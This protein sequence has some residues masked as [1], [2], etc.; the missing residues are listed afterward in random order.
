[1]SCAARNVAVGRRRA[2]MCACA[3]ALAS[4]LMGAF[5]ATGA[6]AATSQFEALAES[7]VPLTSVAVNPATNTIYA[8]QY[9]G[10]KFY[11]YS[12]ST[13]AWTELAAAPLN[14]G[15]N[16]GAAYLNGRIYTSYTENGTELGVYDIAEGKW[17][18]IANPLEG[19]TADI[20]AYGED[21]YLV[22]GT[23]FVSYDPET[24]VTTELAAPPSFAALKECES[25]FEKWGA[26][27]PYEGKIYGD[28]GNGCRGFA[29]YDVA[30]NSWSE[31]PEL[32]NGAVAGGTIDPV[33]ASYFAYGNYG[34]DSLYRY[35]I[36]GGSWHTIELPFKEV[37]DGGMAYVSLAGHSGVYIIQGQEADAFTRFGGLSES[38]LIT[39]LSATLTPTLGGGEVTYTAKVENLG[40]EG[41][42]G[43]TLK[44]TLPAGMTLLSAS[45]TPGSCTGTTTV[46]CSLGTLNVKASATVT[47]KVSAK[48]GTYA[49]SVAVSSEGFEAS[50][51]FKS[52]SAS[53][54]IASALT[55]PPVVVPAPAVK[56]CVV[57]RLRG[58]PL[59]KVKRELKAGG[60]RVGRVVR[61]YNRK[62]RKGSIIYGNPHAHSTLPAGTRVNLWV[63]L[64]KVPKKG[65]RTTKGVHPK[66]AA[67]TPKTAKK[68]G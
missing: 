58:V 12:P 64:G 11:S 4:A 38:D 3:A 47:I 60:C 37:N 22:V 35:S 52:A 66:H 5:A 40:P 59:A 24:K 25:G 23:K 62:I 36:V 43:A 33:S 49:N 30:T 34:G 8:Q 9:E 7:P 54:A 39:S 44:D 26:L 21:L 45:S 18:T 19:G 20:T 51:L 65:A 53:T 2:V 15:N 6:R 32:P 28:Q 63:S 41:A 55:P 56:H 61:H 46:T 42:P 48:P 10:T 50:E 31:L 1:M 57:P 27:A 16:G 68:T 29:V 13:N 67:P 14:S 17:S